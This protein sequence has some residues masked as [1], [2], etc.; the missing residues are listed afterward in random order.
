VIAKAADLL[1]FRRNAEGHAG[2]REQQA[3]QRQGQPAV[4]FDGG[5]DRLT[6]LVHQRGGGHGVDGGFALRPAVRGFEHQFAARALT[7]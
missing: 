2:E 4:Q 1:P 5:L 7:W 3:G 6:R